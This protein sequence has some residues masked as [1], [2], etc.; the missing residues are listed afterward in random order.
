MLKENQAGHICYLNEKGD[1]CGFTIK[2][3]LY[4]IKDGFVDIAEIPGY[5]DSYNEY[6]KE[7][8]D[9]KAT[10]IVEM[11]VTNKY[12]SEFWDSNEEDELLSLGNIW[13]NVIDK[14]GK[15]IEEDELFVCTNDENDPMGKSGL[16]CTLKKGETYVGKLVYVV[17]KNTLKNC[18]IGLN[19]DFCRVEASNSL[20]G[21]LIL[22]ENKEKS[23]N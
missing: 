5:K 11:E 6:F 1:N 4:E 18:K 22:L 10:V 16:L 12:V 2:V 21:L 17:N 7:N 23:E 9:E 19:V 13:L 14:Y 15:N 3:K 8:S 20:K